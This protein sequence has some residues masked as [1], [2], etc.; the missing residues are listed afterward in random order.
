MSGNNLPQPIMLERSPQSATAAASSV[1]QTATA[2]PSANVKI[3]NSYIIQSTGVHTKLF[4]NLRN[5]NNLLR[6]LPNWTN[7]LQKYIKVQS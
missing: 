3:Y 4:I 5:L 7:I 1:T 6:Y 2:V